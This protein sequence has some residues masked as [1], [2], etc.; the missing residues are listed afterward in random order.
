MGNALNRPRAAKHF[1]RSS[2]IPGPWEGRWKR[3]EDLPPPHK[4]AC[5]QETTTATQSGLLVPSRFESGLAPAK[6]EWQRRLAAFVDTTKCVKEPKRGGPVFSQ[7]ASSL[8]VGRAG[9]VDSRWSCVGTRW[10]MS[11]AAAAGRQASREEGEAHF[12]LHSF[13]LQRQNRCSAG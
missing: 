1:G 12:S 3:A 4:V 9:S 10:S 13:S 6:R 7:E 2:G 8:V 11:A 5:W